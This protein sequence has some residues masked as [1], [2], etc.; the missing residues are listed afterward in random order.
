MAGPLARIQ[1][2]WRTQRRLRRVRRL[3]FR[4]QQ[5]RAGSPS[6]RS[7]ADAR[8]AWTQYHR[9]FGEL[10]PERIECAFRAADDGAPA[11]QSYLIDE[12]I[13][14]DA[15][16]ANLYKSRVE[17]VAGRPWSILPGGTTAAD[18]RA[19]QA[20]EDALREPD[21][22]FANSVSH[23]L[24]ANR[25]GY[26]ASEVVWTYAR[27]RRLIVPAGFVDVHPSHF[28]IA[29]EQEL[30]LCTRNAPLG[31]PL[32]PGSWI[33]VALPGTEPLACRGLGRITTTYSAVKLVGFRNWTG[34][35][36]QYG[37][38]LL[39]LKL[40]L[41]GDDTDQPGREAGE[42][43]LARL[44]EDLKAILPADATLEKHD[45]ARPD[46][47]LHQAF[48]EWID[49]QIARAVSGVTLAN[50]GGGTGA[51]YA[52][53]RVHA[54][55]RWQLILRDAVLLSEAFSRQVARPFVEFNGMNARPPRITWH[56]VQNLSP[57]LQVQLFAMATNEAGLGTSAQQLR[58]LTGLRPPIDDGDRLPGRVAGAASTS[59]A[60][61]IMGDE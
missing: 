59:G 58:E 33:V 20:L 50:D 22:G 55:V 38:P 37:I 51:T 48:E 19:A 46:A 6:K 53:G 32:D 44:G 45:G 18:V 13:R 1:Q 42:E 9:Y 4:T 49:R 43:L 40:G 12:L 11:D 26:A 3:A 28:R 30:L 60:P 21:T 23:W 27:R 61:A 35:V 39:A 34:Y 41:A 2:W 15:S 54:D 16:T 36:A 7:Q 8:P 14:R 47:S 57:A 10:D 24:T 52:L 17:A 29:R 5:T 25:Y 56:T 31:E